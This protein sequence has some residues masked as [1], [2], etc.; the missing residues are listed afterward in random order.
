MVYIRFNFNIYKFNNVKLQFIFTT[1]KF[2]AKYE[3]NWER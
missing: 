2:F 3:A 1:T